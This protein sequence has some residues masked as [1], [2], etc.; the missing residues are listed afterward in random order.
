MLTRLKVDGFKN[1]VGVDVRFGPFTCIAGA[2]GSGKSNLFDAIRFL[3]LLADSSLMDA[4]KSVRAEDDKSGNVRSLFHCVDGQYAERMAFEAEMIIPADGEDDLGQIAQATTTFVRYKLELGYREPENS[5]SFQPSTLEILHEELV[6]INKSEFKKNIFFPFSPEWRD[7]VAMGTRRGAGYISTIRE[8]D[9]LFI[10]Q[11]QDGN[12]G[13]PV[14]RRATNLP[15][16]ILSAASA[17]ETPTAILA[18]REMQSWR[19]LQLEPS[20]MRKPDSFDAPRRLGT[21]G[22]HLPA[23]L[24]RL[25]S[26]SRDPDQVF[27][28]I[29]NRLSELIEDIDTIWIDV[30]ER[31]EQYVLN[32]TTQDGATHAAQALSDGTLRF[33]T[34]ALLEID[35][36][37]TGVICLEEPENGIHPGR[38]QAMCD[39]LKGIAVDT[40]HYPSDKSNPLRQVI[41]N[42]HSPT[43][44]QLVPEDSVLMAETVQAQRDGT[45]FTKVVFRPLDEDTNGKSTWRLKAGDHPAPAALGTV[46]S[47]LDPTQP[48][49]DDAHS[50]PDNGTSKRVLD[51]ADIRQLLLPTLEN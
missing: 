38:I 3:S 28:Q 35:P 14:K 50:T 1:L 15:R 39:L 22:A 33:L 47:F 23:T 18:R 24:M 44:V 4:A 32:L 36:S 26:Q 19:L 42:T 13:R 5:E 27:T 41:I 6:H 2:N 11:H 21:N 48:Y 29:A 7:S 40:T 45:W 49:L 20:A 51:R 25:D 9:Q 17:A 30:D 46:I 12:Q 37:E 34:L 16:T 31:R 8:S 43:L 10:Q